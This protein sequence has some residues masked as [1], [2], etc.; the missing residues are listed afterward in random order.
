MTDPY[1]VIVVG[2]R[3]A[4]SPLAMLLARQGRRV[5]LVDQT[6]FPSDTLS[7]HAIHPP[8]VAALRRWGLLHAVMDTGAPP[9]D[10]YTFDF[11]PFV[12]SGTPRMA[13]GSHTSYAPRRTVLDKILV[14][15][16]VRAGAE[17]RELFTFEDVVRE[18]GRVVGIVG[19]DR[20][21]RHVTERAAVVVGADGRNSELASAVHPEQYNETPKLQISYYTY[22]SGLPVK[23]ME[24]VIRPDRGMAAIPTN[25]GLTLV[26][27]A[28]PFAEAS[29]YKADIEGFY[30]S[31]VA[32]EP[33]FGGRV[34][35]AHREDR[36]YGGAVPGFFRKPYGPGWALVGD[37]G[38][39]RDP[40]TAQ[41]ISDS[42]RDAELLASAIGDVLS[43]DRSW[44]DALSDY[45]R[46]RDT[47]VLPMYDFTAGLAS[48]EPPPPEQAAL[49]EA[50]SH[51][52]DS[53]DE[54]AAVYSGVLS[55]ADFF[56]P[57]SVDRVMARAK[58]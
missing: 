55:P 35:D 33:E 7:T 30:S 27:A 45:Q 21:G 13:D 5:L 38:Y 17:L 16:A 15:A 52:Q 25:D 9:F 53:M 4:G 50:C 34:A 41:G 24:S 22:F 39:N 57:E 29:Q 6:E 8:G 56:S 1:D 48:L 36:F 11:G 37:A 14:D 26:V 42:F 20:D 31:I 28:A 23:G 32:L 18:E 12:L 46:T 44:D 2:A 54:F 3:C 40:I 19:R 49:L 10:I 43:A 51:A 47:H 58:V